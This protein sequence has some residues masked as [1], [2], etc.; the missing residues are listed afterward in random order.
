MKTD[1]EIMLDIKKRHHIKE[2]IFEI[3]KVLIELKLR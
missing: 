1:L 2:N 3:Y